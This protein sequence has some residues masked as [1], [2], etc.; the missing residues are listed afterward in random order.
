[1]ALL[2]TV[3]GLVVVACGA[4]THVERG[5]YLAQNAA[6]LRTLPAFPQ[7]RLVQVGSSPWKTSDDEGAAIGG[8][9][10]TRIYAL[11]PATDGATAISFYRRALTPNWTEVAGSTEYVGMKRGDAYLHV[12]AGRGRV[13]V[14]VDH[15]C[16][17]G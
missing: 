10:T 17:K 16:Y 12:L 1:A 3:A 9:F 2:I 7:A 5:P 13:L 6:L 4:S 14:E 8:Y 11:P 15:D